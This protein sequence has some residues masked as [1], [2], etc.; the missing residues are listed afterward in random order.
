MVGRTTGVEGSVHPTIVQ[1]AS[2]IQWTLHYFT[3]FLVFV[4]KYIIF[5]ILLSA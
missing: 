3:A 5:K 2:K 1:G 4:I